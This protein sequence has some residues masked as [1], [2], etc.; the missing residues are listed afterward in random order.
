[1]LFGTTAKFHDVEIHMNWP[2]DGTFKVYPGIYH[3]LYL[4]TAHVNIGHASHQF[5][6]LFRIKLLTRTIS[7]FQVPLKPENLMTDYDQDRLL[8]FPKSLPYKRKYITG[9]VFLISL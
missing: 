7:F 3:Q 4:Y 9:C 8:N 2:C 5:M 1:M 6:V